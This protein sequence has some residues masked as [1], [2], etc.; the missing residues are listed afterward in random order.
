VLPFANM[1]DDP[2]DEYFAGAM[3]EDIITALSRCNWLSVIA[4]FSSCT[5]V[6]RRGGRRIGRQ[7][8]VDY[9]RGN[10]RRAGSRMRTPA[11][12]VDALSG[13]QI[14]ADRF[15]DDTCEIFDL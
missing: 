6:K 1:S 7:P 9:S 3:A 8:R 11:Q 4:R 2:D 13:V 14:W 15:D 5:K 10:I 12:L